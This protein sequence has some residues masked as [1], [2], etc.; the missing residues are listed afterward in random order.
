MK[1]YY[2]FVLTKGY[3]GPKLYFKVN[4]WENYGDFA[5]KIL[6]YSYL[7]YPGNGGGTIAWLVWGALGWIWG[8]D[9]FGLGL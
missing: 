6:I 4:N 3:P 5:L 9:G 8:N 1:E 2:I 7:L